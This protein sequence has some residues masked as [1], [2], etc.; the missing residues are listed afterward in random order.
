M[1]NGSKKK[2]LAGTLR[3]QKAQKKCMLCLKM[4]NEYSHKHYTFGDRM[5][6]VGARAVPGDGIYEKSH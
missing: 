3:F 4:S 5:R 2:K 1:F 6:T